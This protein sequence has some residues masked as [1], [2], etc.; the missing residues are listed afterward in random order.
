MWLFSGTTSNFQGPRDTVN[1]LQASHECLVSADEV[2][3][4]LVEASFPTNIAK[5]DDVCMCCVRSAK[6]L[7]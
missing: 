5:T 4:K 1:C 6:S 2:I 7:S 3:I